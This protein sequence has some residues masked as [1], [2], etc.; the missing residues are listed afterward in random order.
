MEEV[1]KPTSRKPSVAD[2]SIGNRTETSNPEAIRMPLAR[3]TRTGPKRITRRSA[4]KRPRAMVLMNATY[5]ICTSPGPG[6]TT[7][8]K[9]TPLQSNMVPWLTMLPKAISPMTST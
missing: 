7:L 2:H 3:R 8:S 4:V 1:P 6:F 9:Y 5:P